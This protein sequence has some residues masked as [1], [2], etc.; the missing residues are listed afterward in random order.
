MREELKKN[1]LKKRALVLAL[2]YMSLSWCSQINA[3]IERDRTY[4]YELS[5]TESESFAT[6]GKYKLYFG[7][8]EDLNYYMDNPYNICIVDG[9][10]GDNPNFR[11]CDSF[12]ITND[13]DMFNILAVL[14]EYEKENPSDWNR[15]IEGLQI[16][17][18]AHNMSYEYGLLRDRS[19]SVDLDSKDAILYE[20]N[21]IKLVFGK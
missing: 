20:D 12:R 8:E 4:S 15:T 2:M 18:V 11:I 21:L 16:E 9:R 10:F 19:G 3:S 6:Y 7:S 1:L 5:D 14:L 17:W 13:E